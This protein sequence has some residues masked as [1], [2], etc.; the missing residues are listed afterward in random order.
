VR[1]IHHRIPA[2]CAGAPIFFEKLL[3]GRRKNKKILPYLLMAIRVNAFSNLILETRKIEFWSDALPVLRLGMRKRR[4]FPPLAPVP[5]CC[6]GSPKTEL[7]SLFR[8]NQGSSQI[9]QLVTAGT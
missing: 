8:A 6:T 2:W 1:A 3:P 7:P 5:L 9:L 4:R